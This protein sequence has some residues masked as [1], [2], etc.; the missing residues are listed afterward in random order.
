VDFGLATGVAMAIRP[1][2]VGPGRV[3]AAVATTRYDDFYF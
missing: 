2:L 1:I 3:R